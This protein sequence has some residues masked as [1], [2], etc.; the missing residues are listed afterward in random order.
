MKVRALSPQQIALWLAKKTSYISLKGLNHY[1][2]R[3]DLKDNSGARFVRE[4]Q[5]RGMDIRLLLKNLRLSENKILVLMLLKR[6]DWMDLLWLMDKS[7]L[8]IGLR[9]FSKDKLLRLMTLLPK[10]LLIKMLLRVF[11]L[12]D[13]IKRMPISEMM[14]IFRSKRLPVKILVKAMKDLNDRRFLMQLMGKVTGK[15][16]G[17][18]TNEEM[19]EMMKKFKKHRIMDGMR[20]LPYKALQ[21]FMKRLITQDPE[22]MMRMTGDFIFRQFSTLS[23][24][25]LMMPFVLVEKD[26][27]IKMLSFLPDKFIMQIAATIDDKKFEDYLVSQQYGL[28]EW[29]GNSLADAA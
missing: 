18:L 19:L 21:P 10:R 8:V 15:E 16:M 25:E 12:K 3:K 24:P 11:P 23:K 20:F 28:L 29:L 1:A 17:R 7:K 26:L 9:F 14:H 4:N 13:L 6:S 27:L 22:L 5:W 2:N